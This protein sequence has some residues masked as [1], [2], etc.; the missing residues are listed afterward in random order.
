MERKVPVDDVPTL[1][2]GTYAPAVIP[3]VYSPRLRLFWLGGGLSDRHRA[4][5]VDW[6]TW[7]SLARELG[8]TVAVNERGFARVCWKDKASWGRAQQ[9]ISELKRRER[10]DGR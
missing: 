9:A 8:L 2:S 7:V 3:G 10:G 6:E 4:R 5:L 1:L